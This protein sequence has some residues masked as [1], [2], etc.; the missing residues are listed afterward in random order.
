MTTRPQLSY[1]NVGRGASKMFNVYINDRRDLL[2]VRKGSPVPL[3]IKGKW[4]KR[5]RKVISVSEEIEL[6]VERQGYY[7][8]KLREIKGRAIVR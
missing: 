4:R 1:S 2:V 8:R 3:G 5:K 7:M 6:A